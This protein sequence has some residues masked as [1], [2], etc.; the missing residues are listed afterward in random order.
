MNKENTPS[1][2]G[3]AVANVASPVEYSPSKILKSI[4]PNKS[5]SSVGKLNFLQSDNLDEHFDH[6]HNS[7]QVILHQLY[8]LEVQTKQTHVDLGQ[9][10]DRLKNNNQHLNKLLENIA[11]YST[12]VITEG[13]ATKLDIKGLT[14]KLDSLSETQ[15]G[16]V[17]L[18]LEKSLAEIKTLESLQ[19]LKGSQVE[20]EQIANI[21]SKVTSLSDQLKQLHSTNKL[22]N[23]SGIE[24]KQ[25]IC[26]RIQEQSQIL[27]DKLPELIYSK[28]DAKLETKSQNDTKSF[29][30]LLTQL[31][32]ITN[33]LPDSDLVRQII[34]PIVAELRSVSLDQRSL[35]LLENIL[36]RLGDKKSE[37]DLHDEFFLDVRSG[38]KSIDL[39]ITSKNDQIDSLSKKYD[40]Q[41]RALIELRET[42]KLQ[43]SH[44]DLELKISQLD[45]KYQL[46]TTAYQKKYEDFK[47]LHQQYKS[48]ESNIERLQIATPPPNKVKKLAKVRQ[49]HE[50]KLN[51]IYESQYD[52]KNNANRR[53]VSSPLIL[54][55][56]RFNSFEP[57]TEQ[58]EI[59][60]NSDDEGF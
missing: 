5:S 35:L 13:N 45:S 54:K 34:D 38:L 25:Q 14:E 41:E 32:S 16:K 56:R 7:H 19:M 59:T 30:N 57:L 51:E 10:F 55:D 3:K 2:P 29:D 47:N 21:E 27:Q 48:L 11:N 44:D 15:N 43:R 52:S 50:S 22:A 49:L 4:S 31:E 28:I 9:L 26:S 18:A 37:N 42:Q 17:L 33:S 1:T 6:I 60:N 8:N 23:D 40:A 12:E 36:N 53:F 39:L 24:I 46:L 58:T 20:P